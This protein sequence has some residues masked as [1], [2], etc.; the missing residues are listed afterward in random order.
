V[1][2]LQRDA[3]STAV[4]DSVVDAIGIERER[5]RVLIWDLWI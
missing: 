2:W 4:I 3:L 5:E 1:D